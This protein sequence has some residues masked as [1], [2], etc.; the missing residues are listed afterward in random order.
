MPTVVPVVDK[1]AL[2][3]ARYLRVTRRMDAVDYDEMEPAEWR[4]LQAALRVAAKE[5]E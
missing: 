4:R 3:W 1:T 5:D 2:A